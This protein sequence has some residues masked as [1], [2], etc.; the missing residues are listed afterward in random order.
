MS[1]SEPCEAG[2]R[3]LHEGH[4]ACAVLAV[5]LTDAEHQLRHTEMLLLRTLADDVGHVAEALG[6]EDVIARGNGQLYGPL[7]LLQAVVGYGKL[8]GRAHAE[9][10]SCNCHFLKVL[11]VGPE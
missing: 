11:V 4:L 1:N 5:N 6:E 9:N 7:L 8:A 10:R 2:H 3:S